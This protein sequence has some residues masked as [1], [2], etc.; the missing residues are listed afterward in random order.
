MT[1][2][3]THIDTTPIP[4]VSPTIPP[5]PDYTPA[6]P[7]YSPAYDTEF[8]PSEDPSSYHIP[9]LPA[10][11]PFLS[12]TYDSS[13]SDIHD[14]PPSPTHGT[15]FTETTLSTQRSPIAFDDLS[16]SSSSATSSDSSAYA[17]FD[18]ASSR[19]SSD[20]SLP[21]SS[22]GTRPSHYLCSLVPSTHHSS[23]DSERPSH[24]SSFASPSRKRSRSHAAS[25]IWSLDSATDLEDCSKDSF[26]PY[27]P[28][29]VGL[30]VDFEDESTEPSRSRGTDL[31]MD[32][33]VKR[34][35][36]IEIHPEIQA[37]INECIA[38]AD[39]LRGREIDARVIVEAIDRKEIETGMRGPVEVRVD[40]VTHL[41][42]VDD[43]LGPA[44]EG[45][46]ERD[47][48]DRIVAVGQQ[49]AGILERIQE[50]EQDNKRLRDMMDVES[51]RVT[52]FQRRELRV[53]RELRQIRHFR[54]YDCMRI[55]SL[56][57]MPNTRS[58]ATMTREAVNELIARRVAEALKARDAARNLEP[59]AEGG[60]EHGGENG[61]D[62]EGGNGREDENGKGNRGVNGNRNGGG[63]GNGDGNGNDNRDGNGNKGG[64]GYENHNVN[65][66]GFR[67][68]ARECTYQDFLMC[69]PLNFK[70]TEG[71][72]GGSGEP[73][74]EPDI[75]PEIQEEIDKAMPNTRSEATMTREAVNKLIARRVAKALEAR[76]NG[77][78]NHNV[79][80]RGFKH[81]AR[82]C[83]YQ[84]F[85]MCQPLNFKGTEGV[86]RS[87]VLS[88]FSALLDVES[89]TL[90]TSYAI[91]LT[92][93]RIQKP[94]LS[95]E[96]TQKYMQRGCQVYLA[97]VTS[98]KTEDMLEEKR[99]EDVPI[100]SE[101]LKVFPEDLPGLPPARQVEFQID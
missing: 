78:E 87:F 56:E 33:D 83:T 3:T 30:G 53:Q 80:F 82:E 92:D 21:A 8:D 18:S 45:A 37:E 10:T 75:D 99:L 32:V 64:N 88:S 46:V 28:R 60:D 55:A 38:Y 91:K 36:G 85:L 50:L 59:L 34:S 15:P 57:T 74:S 24:D 98:K 17:L 14:T 63:N 9:P 26:E 54:F 97:Q 61:E 62:Y 101:F 89:S 77:Y 66:R 68:V 49:S 86:V 6:S 2:P 79:N 11:L 58:E 35:N 73:Y 40:K 27:V 29:E 23:T 31:E 52:R 5:S 95:L 76:G 39:A 44:Q 51:Q 7:D 71:F 70:G 96:G 81:V 65:F 20:H 84:D 100:V 4:T 22:S 94:M 1:S 16:S 69:Q 47:Q 42:V 41:V 67:R 48:E 93:G 19:S 12:S 43:I 13:G 90:D 25:R 72:V